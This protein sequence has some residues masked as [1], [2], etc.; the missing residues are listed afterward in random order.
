MK[1][2]FILDSFALLVF[3]QKEQ[4]HEKI[5]ELLEEAKRG[6]IKLFFSE[7]SLGEV[8]YLIARRRGKE[9]AQEV[10][11]NLV[12]LPINFVLPNRENI[13]QAGEFKSQG[14]I[15][16]ADCFVLDLAKI[17]KAT[18][19]TGDPEFKKFL[20]KDKILWVG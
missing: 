14:N 6:R 10:L 1:S 5:Q 8:Y 4:G 12:E 3:Y 9:K 19:V 13:L 7:I 18:V 20:K 16:Y 11:A 17:H 2:Q 15:A